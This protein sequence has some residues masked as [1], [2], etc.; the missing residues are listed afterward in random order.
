VHGTTGEAPLARFLRD[1]A[2]TLQPL[3]DR[4][5]FQPMR[6]WTRRVQADC[7]IELH[8]N[9]YSVPWQLLGES[10]RVVQQGE[11][12]T[13]HHAASVVATHQL[14]HGT[15]VRRVDPAHLAGITS[16]R[17]PASAPPTPN[18]APAIASL[19]RPLS[20]YAAAIGEHFG[21][22]A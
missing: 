3:A 20:E 15:R 16:R 18:H 8:R 12:L 9:W 2:H 14:A 21:E 17:A 6:E 22:A 11:Q 13:I 7:T 5:R 4:P 19:L 10:V 1:E